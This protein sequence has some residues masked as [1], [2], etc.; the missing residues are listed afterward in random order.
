MTDSDLFVSAVVAK[1]A[2]VTFKTFIFIFL[3]E[4]SFPK[5]FALMTDN[6]RPSYWGG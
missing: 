5:V 3:R 1:L 4:K 2:L 6:Q